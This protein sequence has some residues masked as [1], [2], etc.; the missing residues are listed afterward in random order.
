MDLSQ[1]DLSNMEFGL[2]YEQLGTC[3]KEWVDDEIANA[4]F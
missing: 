2:D 1:D 4:D 3:E